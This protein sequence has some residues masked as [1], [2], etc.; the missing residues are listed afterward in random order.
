MAPALETQNT[1][2]FKGQQKENK[3]N[4]VQNMKG[5]YRDLSTFSKTVR[6]EIA[7]CN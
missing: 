7:I 6:D 1:A 3:I 2:I 5:H 4:K